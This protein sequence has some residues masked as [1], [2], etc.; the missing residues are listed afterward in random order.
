MDEVSAG[1]DLYDSGCGVTWWRRSFHCGHK[2]LLLGVLGDHCWRLSCSDV[3]GADVARCLCQ[4]V[5][6]KTKLVAFGNLDG[7]F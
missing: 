4:K 1:V 6:T 7:V 2:K 3:T 5:A